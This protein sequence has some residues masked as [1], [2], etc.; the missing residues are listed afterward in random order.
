MSLPPWNARNCLI[1]KTDVNRILQSLGIAMKCKKIS[2]Y[3][4]A[5][6]HKSYAIQKKTTRQLTRKQSERNSSSNK[7]IDVFPVDVIAKFK[8]CVPLQPVSYETLEFLGDS[9]LGFV[10][11]DYLDKRYPNQDE[12]FL[13]RTRSDLVRKETLSKLSKTLGLEKFILISEHV[14][15]TVTRNCVHIL[16]DCLEALF[17]AIYKDL[18][19]DVARKFIINLMESEIDFTEIILNDSN[20]KDILLRFYQQK[21]WK[22]PTYHVEKTEGPSH[23]R[24]FTM[25]VHDA[26]GNQVGH[27]TAHSKKK[28]EQ[29]A[30]KHALMHF[31]I[32]KRKLY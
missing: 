1:Q 18:G 7:E 11:A 5:L 24:I 4:C 8:H 12:G 21:G 20:Y 28:A 27:G 10:I 31:G 25:V 17:G 2:H 32:I 14:E 3:R 30:S 13:T 29:N 16:E 19:I 9:V 6:T 26:N 15:N 23:H 22:H